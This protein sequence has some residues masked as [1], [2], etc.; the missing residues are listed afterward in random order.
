MMLM[1]DAQLPMLSN[2]L[3]PACTTQALSLLEALGQV[4]WCHCRCGLA[5]RA[6]AAVEEL[7]E[8]WAVC[9]HAPDGAA[10]DRI[11]V[12]V[13]GH[14]TRQVLGPRAILGHSHLLCP[15]EWAASSSLLRA[16]I[17]ERRLAINGLAS[18]PIT[19]VH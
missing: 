5:L 10:E 16:D 13:H 8:L 19:G 2:A 4:C 7:V 9:W 1:F 15:A 12:V 6:T 14:A 3:Q 17:L 11:G 18:D